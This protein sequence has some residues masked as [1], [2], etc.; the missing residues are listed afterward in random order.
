MK[1]KSRQ[2]FLG[3]DA[4]TAIGLRTLVHKLN[5]I[6]FAYNAGA[7]RECP[8]YSQI[9]IETDLSIEQ[10]EQWLDSKKIDYVGV[11]QA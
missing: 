8:E 3:I 6:G 11:F 2:N 10:L 7:Y 4:H 5:K 1:T 9:H